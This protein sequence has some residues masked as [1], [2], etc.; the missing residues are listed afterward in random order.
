MN[1]APHKPSEHQHS[2]INHLKWMGG[3]AVGIFMVLLLTGQPLGSA[4][5]L[6]IL[7]ACP[8]MMVA[9]MFTMGRGER[10]AENT[11]QVTD[12]IRD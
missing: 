1:T 2:G 3:I 6:S 12:D 11:P 9:M 4:I 10:E 8:L 7:L 5:F